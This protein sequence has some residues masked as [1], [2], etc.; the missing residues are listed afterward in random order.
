MCLPPLAGGFHARD[1]H[2][3][4]IIPFS[5]TQIR[6]N[7]SVFL[8]HAILNRLHLA[9]APLTL[10]AHL[11]M[12][13]ATWNVN[14]VRT[15]LPHLVDWLTTNP[16][17]VICLQETKVTDELF[18]REALE[19]MGYTVAISG[20]KS[21]NGVALI[22]QNPLLDV[23]CGFSAILG[24]QVAEF[25][26]Q[27][28]VITGVLD[29]VRIVDL[30]VPNGSAVGSDKYQYKLAWLAVLRQYLETLLKDSPKL[31][32]CGDFNIA[33]ADIDIH[34]PKGR[35]KQVMATDL[36]RQALQQAVFDL[37][38]TDVF[39]QFTPDGGHFSWW[40]YR[41]GAF[42]RDAGWRIDHIYL[43]PALATGAIA[44]T[45]DKAPRKL[46]QPSDHTPVIAEFN[47]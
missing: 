28:R 15:R 35:E 42:R 23:S 20:Q 41:T 5:E 14:S 38:L 37:G 30:Y 47:P 19:T 12:Q 31:L 39:R 9:A 18:P 34:D 3:W 8:P 29:D 44:C 36:E 25:D 26:E 11:A 46:E 17:D 16:V 27:K 1:G 6:L 10:S 45:I 4:Y 21:Y 33:M 22:S 7:C 2:H 43:S 40:D 24:D 32:V 13:V